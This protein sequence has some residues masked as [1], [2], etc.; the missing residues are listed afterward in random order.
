MHLNS[1]FIQPWVGYI[2]LT[3][4]MCVEHYQ[5]RIQ[6]MFLFMK[7]FSFFLLIYIRTTAPPT[8]MYQ[9]NCT[10]YLYILGQLHL[11]PIYIR[12]TAPPTCMYQDNCTHFLYIRKT[13]PTTYIY[14]DTCTHYLYI[15]TTAPT[16]FIYQDNCT[17][18]LCVHQDNCT[19]YLYIRTTAPPP[20][21]RITTTSLP[22]CWILNLNLNLHRVYSLPVLNSPSLYSLY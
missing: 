5:N 15:R 22:S 11:L 3:E 1:G 12:T 2:L 10:H 19:H 14:Q 13:A 21:V 8:Y 17:P 6:N 20:Y 4:I 16:T 9:D 18:S 7:I